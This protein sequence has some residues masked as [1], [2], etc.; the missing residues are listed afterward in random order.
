M[1]YPASHPAGG[2]QRRCPNDA[3][4][5][6]RTRVR[7]RGAAYRPKA[8]GGRSQPIHQSSGKE[9][10]LQRD[11]PVSSLSMDCAT[12][13]L[14]GG[15]YSPVAFSTNQRPI[16]ASPKPAVTAKRRAPAPSH[17]Q[18]SNDQRS[19]QRARGAS[20]IG[21]AKSEGSLLLRQS[22][23]HRLQA[24]RKGRSPPNPSTTACD[25]HPTKPIIKP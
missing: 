23:R 20:A 25:A 7:Y 12:T 9:I 19:H 2:S 4:P 5:R 14:E 24:S 18:W 17:S 1:R 22:L 11:S 6:W 3:C 13:D 15:A 8:S 21:N 16:H 10:R